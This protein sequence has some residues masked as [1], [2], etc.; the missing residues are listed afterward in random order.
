M[1]TT[2]EGGVV[3]IVEIATGRMVTSFVAAKGKFVNDVS[4]HPMARSW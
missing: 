4:S 3:N 1:A 2:Q